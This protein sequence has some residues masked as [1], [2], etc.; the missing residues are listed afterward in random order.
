VS[1]FGT[2]PGE[3]ADESRA[4]RT[5]TA[6]GR[7]TLAEHE[8]LIRERSREWRAARFR[9]RGSWDRLGPFE[10]EAELRAAC[11]RR[12]LEDPGPHG[13]GWIIYATADGFSVPVGTED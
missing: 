13:Q 9:G 5:I 2:A 8:Q 1:R 10:T 6:L 11:Q 3:D 7:R 4:R 12:T